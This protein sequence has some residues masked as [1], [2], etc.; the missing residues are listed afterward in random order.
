MLTKKPSSSPNRRITIAP[1]YC[2]LCRAKAVVDYKDVVL[3]K[4]YISDRGKIAPR[5][6]TGICAKHQRQL[7]TEIKKA[8]FLALLPYTDRHAL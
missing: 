6:R 8:R 5:S 4:R 2:R 1:S 7:T 3:L